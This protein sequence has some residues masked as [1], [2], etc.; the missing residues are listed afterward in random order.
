[1][2]ATMGLALLVV[3][4]VA[5]ADAFDCTAGRACIGTEGAD[6]LR[7]SGGSDYMDARQDDD[8]LR[9]YEGHDFM[10]GD[11]FDA[12]DN[13]T[14]TDGDD[15]L[16]GGPGFDEMGGYGGDDELFG[17]TQGDFIFA[18]EA[19]ENKGEDVVYGRSGNDFILARDRVKDTIDCG[20]GDFDIAFFDKGGVDKVAKD[21]EYKNTFPG[22]QFSGASAPSMP[23]RVSAQK[24]D[25]LRAR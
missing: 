25:A 11:A 21:C 17:G 18:E 19:S 16:R 15:F 22:G 4:G 2:L 14:S 13:D 7:G 8:E 3:S 9:G 10:S 23:E 1:M 24:L 20:P 6:T 12:P 5:I